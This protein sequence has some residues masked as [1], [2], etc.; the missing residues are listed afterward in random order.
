MENQNSILSTENSYWSFYVDDKP[1]EPIRFSNGKTQ[2]DVV[3]E[4]HNLI[5]KGE[6]VIFL[7]GVCGTGKS[8]IALNLARVLGK[9]SIVVPIKNLQRQYEEDYMGDKFLL[10]P[11]GRKMKIS[12]I[13]GRDNHD[14]II[15]PGKSC[16]YPFLPDTIPLVEKNYDRLRKFYEEN[17]FISGKNFELKNIKRISVAP[18]NPYW[19]PILPAD[20]ELFQL[21]DAKKKRYRGMRNKDF[22]F[23][24]RKKG[25]SYYDQYEAYINSDVII[26]N[27]AK[28]LLEILMGRKPETEVDIIDECDEF[29]D[30]LSD[31]ENLDLSK[32][33]IPL[34]SIN[35]ENEHVE[36]SI[37]RILELINVEE[38]RAKALGV[39]EDE[40]HHISKTKIVEMI[41][42]ILE[43][44]ELQSETSLDDQ[45]YANKLLEIAMK[46]KELL[47]DTYLTYRK[48]KIT[49]NLSVTLVSTNLARKFK[50]IL[51]GNKALVLMSGTP[52]SEYILKN[53]FKIEKLA[54]VEAENLNQGSIEPSY[55]GKE[56][57]CKY[58]NFTQG[59]FSR[60]EYLDALS[61]SIS[62]AKRP[63]LVHVNAFSDLPSEDEMRIF[64]FKNLVSQ[65][66]LRET[67]NE[68]RKGENV[69]KFKSGE[70][71][72]LFTTRCARGIDFPGEMCNSVVF[73][74]YP[75]PNVG[76]TFWKILRKTHM[77][78][79]W[80]FY[81]DKAKREFLQK[82]YRAVRS[83]DEHIY[84]LSPDKRVLEALKGF[85]NSL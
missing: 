53:I 62:K 10:M 75:N 32:L 12:M 70:T 16:A 34:G 38:K 2:A 82:I 48:D 64:N 45:N 29:L 26:F 52:H 36:E 47:E 5:K 54:F 44:K 76:D 42:I 61:E 27:S 43:N 55:T 20:I 14:S 31:R 11:D 58:S 13:T 66:K 65:E 18:A 22:I 37:R 35:P 19:S 69:Y 7:K 46:F 30:N 56:F 74:K 63:T 51:E 79:Y 84:V 77:M 57:D 40:I 67:Q 72:I 50:E 68:D 9:S 21:K 17:P 85:S 8:A 39:N 1:L 25:C 78:Y 24:H 73:T 80:D 28:Y 81:K 83:K 60:R 3:K 71:D 41:K 15:V 59:N 33:Y 6:R 49:G 23:Y 4:I